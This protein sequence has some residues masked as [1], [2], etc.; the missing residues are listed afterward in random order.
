MH[1]LQQYSVQHVLG[2]ALHLILLVG[3]VLDCFIVDDA[4]GSLVV[5]SI[6]ELVGLGSELQALHSRRYTQS[7]IPRHNTIQL[8]PQEHLVLQYRRC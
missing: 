3:E 6:V 7:T 4:V 8:L 1:L 5:E 2:E